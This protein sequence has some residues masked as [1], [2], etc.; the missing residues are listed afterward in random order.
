MNE[1]KVA[2]E[3]PALVEVGDF[4]ELTQLTNRGKWADSIWGYYFD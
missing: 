3:A 4:T 2:Y 1:N